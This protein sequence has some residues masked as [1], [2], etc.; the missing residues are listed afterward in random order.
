MPR[1]LVVDDDEIFL[2]AVTKNL[3][4]EGFQVVT[5]IN[6]KQALEFFNE[7]NPDLIISDIRMPE[8][9][10]VELI[11]A[12]RT[13]SRVPMILMTGFAEIMETKAAYDLGANEFI[14][15][16]FKFEE[17]SAAIG[18]CLNSKPTPPNE[19]VQYCKLGINDFISGRTIN[20]GIFI[21]LAPNRYIKLAHKGEDISHDR[22]THYRSRGLNFLYLKKNDFRQY[23]GFTGT[24]S[25]QKKISDPDL[26]SC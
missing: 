14:P 17:L 11:K 19:D 7:Q 15:K 12:I 9:D 25:V 22:I 6:G 3:V 1:I 5:A 26:R 21:K 8:M 16:P 20:F 24:P 18:R 13:K 4:A 23:V 2:D 10:G